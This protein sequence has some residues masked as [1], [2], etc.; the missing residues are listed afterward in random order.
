M[1]HSIYGMYKRR[2]NT[3]FARIILHGVSHRTH[4]TV[5]HRHK[6]QGWT[7]IFFRSAFVAV[8]YS[9][10]SLLTFLH[11]H[12]STRPAKRPQYILCVH[13]ISHSSTDR[14]SNNGLALLALYVMTLFLDV[15]VVRKW[16]FSLFLPSL[17][18]VFKCATERMVAFIFNCDGRQMCFL[19]CENV[20]YK[21]VETLLSANN[22]PYPS[23]GWICTR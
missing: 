8:C 21:M 12:T 11:V 1:C 13:C 20:T 22:W 10:V 19:L 2:I 7:E 16:N 17:I 6:L 3:N 4:F 9:K 18:S 14:L 5:N 23:R 15:F